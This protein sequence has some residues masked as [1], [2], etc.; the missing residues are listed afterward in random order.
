MDYTGKKALVLGLGESGLAMA[1]WLAHH[2]AFVRVADTRQSPPN[3]AVW[4]E[5]VQKAG[6]KTEFI[7]GPFTEDLLTGMDFVAISPGLVPHTDLGAIVPKARQMSI[8][9]VS[10]IEL[11][12]QA[13]ADL[14]KSRT[15]R[16]KIIAITGTNGK[17]TVTSLTGAM[18][19]QTGKT[20]KV[21]GNI[22][23]A[24]LDVLFDALRT[25]SL[26]EIWVL[27]L[28]SFQLWSTGSLNADVAVVLNISQDHLDWHESMDAYIEAK[29]RIF[30]PET[31]RVLNRDDPV[32]HRMQTGQSGT[33]AKN[34]PLVVTFGL[35]RPSEPG[36]FGEIHDRGVNWLCTLRETELD[37]GPRK[38]K[39]PPQT[40]RDIQLLMPSGALL[41]KG[42]HNVANA[43]AAIALCRAIGLSM[44]PLLHGARKYRGEPHRVEPVMQVSGV[45]WI[46]DSKATNVGATIA[47]IEGLG[48]DGEKG[49]KHLV[50]IAGG[51]GKDQD[52]SALRAPVSRF[53]RSVFLIGKDAR[54]LEEALGPGDVPRIVCDSL[55]SAVDSAARIAREGD[56]VLLSPACA[57]WDM[58]R[59]YVHRSEVFVSAVKEIAAARGE[60]VL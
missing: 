16:P 30:G 27:E 9:L 31:I 10:E 32:V 22:S 1:R 56:M 17:T 11:F 13:L 20:V 21:A 54:L 50:L 8:P 51:D 59:N 26:P 53:V 24:V 40:T 12:A 55:E 58:F 6:L 41:V 28:S 18:C 35:D 42:R 29:K 47:A 43:L 23:P 25:D 57:S 5:E 45:L 36:D 14:K 34:A 49:E 52:F 37:S 3:S 4:E 15:Y 2:K 60:V 33:A 19:A 38:K 48:Q 44:A 39:E 7:G 46:D